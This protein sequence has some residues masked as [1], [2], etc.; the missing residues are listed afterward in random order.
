MDGW[1]RKVTPLAGRTRDDFPSWL[2]EMC[3]LVAEGKGKRSAAFVHLPLRLKP[4]NL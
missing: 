2:H 4:R 3:Y 1:G